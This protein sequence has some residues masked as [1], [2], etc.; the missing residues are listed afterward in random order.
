MSSTH[1]MLLP[2]R[3]IQFPL[4]YIVILLLFFQ[5]S[6][7]LKAILFMIHI[8]LDLGW[9]QH[10]RLWKLLLSSSDSC[11]LSSMGTSVSAVQSMTISGIY[12]HHWGRLFSI[13]T[14]FS[15]DNA[16]EYGC[17]QPYSIG[18]VS[19]CPSETWFFIYYY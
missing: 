14:V 16:I 7:S 17:P 3:A 5:W 9:C 19:K 4:S 18:E 13:L 10:A 15:L 1:S 8:I 11:P 6:G 12:P 2:M